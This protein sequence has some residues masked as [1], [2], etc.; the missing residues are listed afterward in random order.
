M[1][2][3]KME[4]NLDKNYDSLRRIDKWDD[5]TQDVIKKRLGDELGDRMAF[6]FLTDNEG[7]VL[8]FL[9]DML[10]PQGEGNYIK[11]AEAID[12]TLSNKKYGVR[13]GEN[14]WRGDFYKKGLREMSKKMKNTGVAEEHDRGG[15]KSN[16]SDILASAEDNFLK[17]FLKQVLKDSVIIYYSH[18][19]GWNSIGF[20]GPAY[21]EGYPFLDC[22]EKE[23]WEPDYK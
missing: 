18:P 21:P 13:Y 4:Y 20:P 22:K 23:S 2:A 7:K 9:T 14:P 19:A 6:S 11:I 3:N 16:I 15:E 10:I 8:K 1:P 12:K 17:N 5:E